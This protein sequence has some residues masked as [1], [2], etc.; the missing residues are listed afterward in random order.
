MNS[1]IIV[2]P[3]TQKQYA[4]ESKKGRELLQQYIKQYNYLKKIQSGG[5]NEKRR[6]A[7]PQF[8]ASKRSL[9]Q[10]LNPP[11]NVESY[12]ER[13]AQLLS[14]APDINEDLNNIVN[15]L[16]NNSAY[17]DYPI[18]NSIFVSHIKHL[19]MNPSIIKN[20]Y[21]DKTIPESIYPT[22]E[23]FYFSNYDMNEFFRQRGMPNYGFVKFTIITLDDLREFHAQPLPIP[24]QRRINMIEK[25]MDITQFVWPFITTPGHTEYIVISDNTE[26]NIRTITICNFSD[27][28]I[29][30]DQ[31]NNLGENI[32]KNYKILNY[33]ADIGYNHIIKQFMINIE[34]YINNPN[35]N[36][37]IDNRINYIIQTFSN[38]YGHLIVNNGFN[39]GEMNTTQD[40][41]IVDGSTLKSILTNY[42]RPKFLSLKYQFLNVEGG[43]I[44]GEKQNEETMNSKNCSILNYIPNKSN[45]YTNI[46]NKCKIGGMNQENIEQG[47]QNLQKLITNSANIQQ[48]KYN[49]Q[50][51]FQ[52]LLERADSIHDFR[53]F[54]KTVLGADS[55]QISNFSAI[56]AHPDNPNSNLLNNIRYINDPENWNDI[57]NHDNF[58]QRYQAFV[59]N[60]N[61]ITIG[62]S[63]GI[64][65]LF[66]KLVYISFSD[67][68][69]DEKNVWFYS[70][71]NQLSCADSLKNIITGNENIQYVMSD[72]GT[73]T[74]V[75]RNCAY[76]N[77]LKCP[78]NGPDPKKKNNL[79]YGLL[80]PYEENVLT[81]DVLSAEERVARDFFTS[82]NTIIPN[83]IFN[84]RCRNPANLTGNSL[85]NAINIKIFAIVILTSG[86]YNNFKTRCRNLGAPF[87]INISCTRATSA[88]PGGSTFFDAFYQFCDNLIIKYSNYLNDRDRNYEGNNN[89]FT[90]NV[91]DNNRYYPRWWLEFHKIIFTSGIFDH[92][93][94]LD[95]NTDYTIETY[96]RFNA[97]RVNLL[98]TYTDYILINGKWYQNDDELENQNLGWE[99]FFASRHR[100]TNKQR[101]YKKTQLKYKITFTY[102][103]PQQQQEEME[104]QQEEE[105]GGDNAPI[106]H[107]C[108]INDLL[109]IQQASVLICVLLY[110]K[111][112][113]ATAPL[114]LPAPDGSLWPSFRQIRPI[115]INIKLGKGQL[116]KFVYNNVR[117][118]SHIEELS[119]NILNN[120]LNNTVP[121]INQEEAVRRC[122]YFIRILLD[123]KKCGD[124][125][126]GAA[127]TRNGALF[128]SQDRIAT[129]FKNIYDCRIPP[130]T[131]YQ[132]LQQPPVVDYTVFKHGGS[133]TDVKIIEFIWNYE[134]S[135]FI[136]NNK[137]L[138][139]YDCTN[140]EPLPEINVQT[141][142]LFGR[143]LNEAGNRISLRIKMRQMRSSLGQMGGSVSHEYKK[144]LNIP[145]IREIRKKEKKI[146]IWEKAIN[147]ML[148]YKYPFVLKKKQIINLRDN[149]SISSD[150][151]KWLFYQLFLQRLYH[152]FSLM[153]DLK[154][155]HNITSSTFFDD[156]IE[157]SLNLYENSYY[158]HYCD[159]ESVSKLSKRKENDNI[160]DFLFLNTKIGYQ[161]LIKQS[162]EKIKQHNIEFLF[163]FDR[164]IRKLSLN[165]PNLL[166]EY[167]KY[168]SG[169][170]KLIFYLNEADNIIEKLKNINLNNFIELNIF[171]LDNTNKT[172]PEWL[173]ES[174]KKFVEKMKDKNTLLEKI[175]E[176]YKNMNKT[177]LEYFESKCK[178]T[179]YIAKKNWG[180]ICDQLEDQLKLFINKID[181]INELKK[182]ILGENYSDVTPI[183]PEYYLT[184]LDSSSLD[185]S[186]LDSSSFDSISLDSSSLDSISLD[187]SSL[188]SDIL[189]KSDSPIYYNTLDKRKINE[190][191]GDE[192]GKIADGPANEQIEKDIIPMYPSIQT[193]T[194]SRSSK[195]ERTN[196]DLKENESKSKKRK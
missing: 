125:G 54:M 26:G 121:N 138:L 191:P 11:D 52:K 152:S 78:L 153:E 141:N 39:E 32:V 64:E 176:K 27:F 158:K 190:D 51:F 172:F 30:N 193:D 182:K 100:M 79:I 186:S 167:L 131:I 122:N 3:L 18:F 92:Y 33:L 4:I 28:T 70:E 192:S 67:L 126:Q 196:S 66:M 128:C 68:L 45:N 163:K 50:L 61:E 130:P 36:L 165:T 87:I 35:I 82:G 2:D 44:G 159:N 168:Y 189:S 75:F 154:C 99:D 110:W 127:A 179:S 17:W 113:N 115:L 98:D 37:R 8:N 129:I 133:L 56:G 135:N 187:S 16:I 150:K 63:G 105:N 77:D 59:R 160:K 137:S 95:N 21:Y 144:S 145:K 19:K 24:Q 42:Y 22:R 83:N 86:D 73:G 5:M 151:N 96:D 109:S 155:I 88:D 112:R 136:I 34:P 142:Q 14:Y 116:Y 25:N 139:Y 132:D 175:F 29:V 156:L 9:N 23:I 93:R 111:K 134:N 107:S 6:I 177:I 62:T 84:S 117:G 169:I 162:N 7:L 161:S 149:V 48:I 171:L 108:I 20:I 119:N 195:R 10:D 178:K 102:Q 58:R 106:T 12:L 13:K 43:L 38:Y 31:T 55:P 49:F 170:N 89:F 164:E 40:N 157:S 69:I 97:F 60:L 90:V 120:Y 46:L 53:Y 1:K 114:E 181:N 72:P 185:S 80:N 166:L 71:P 41:F 180:A 65:D 15:K 94:T 140:H 188:D 123:I 76:L 57:V 124:W 101:K 146:S 104:I 81:N 85:V 47:F 103:P 174:I 147:K 194:S 74:K 173:S 143:Y 148:L 183:N 91:N 118:L 184:I